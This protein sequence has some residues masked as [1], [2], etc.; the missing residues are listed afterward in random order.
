MLAIFSTRSIQNGKT[1][2]VFLWNDELRFYYIGFIQCIKAYFP[3][4]LTLCKAEKYKMYNEGIFWCG[5][6]N[7]NSMDEW[8]KGMFMDAA[9]LSWIRVVMLSF[10]KTSQVSINF[11]EIFNCY[12]FLILNILFLHQ[13]KKNP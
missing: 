7:D 3:R 8:H 12:L 4:C 11:V 6:K 2:Q 10:N 1:T 13:N 9:I 5:G